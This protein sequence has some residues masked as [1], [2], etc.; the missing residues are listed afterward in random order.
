MLLQED[1]TELRQKIESF[2]DPALQTSHSHTSLDD[3]M[4]R[5][6]ITEDVKALYLLAL[7]GTKSQ[8]V[9][10]SRAY[11]ERSRSYTRII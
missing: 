5:E 4:Q 3:F 10:Q 2:I 6:D 8:E 1:E 7:E 11:H 9:F